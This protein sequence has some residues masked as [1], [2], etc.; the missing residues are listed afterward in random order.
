MP[1]QVR[2]K[3]HKITGYVLRETRQDAELAWKPPEKR[4]LQ[5]HNGS[6]SKKT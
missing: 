6:A 4:A 3:L 5:L 2:A 1:D